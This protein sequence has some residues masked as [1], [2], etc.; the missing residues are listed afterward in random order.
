MHRGVSQPPAL[1]PPVRAN[2]RPPSRDAS[3]LAVDREGATATGSVFTGGHP[4]IPH[5]QVVAVVTAPT[6]DLSSATCRGLWASVT[7][8]P[9]ASQAPCEGETPPPTTLP[10]STRTQEAASSIPPAVFCLLGAR[11]PVW[12]KEIL[13]VL[14]KCSCRSV[15]SHIHVPSP[16]SLPPSPSVCLSVRPSVRGGRRGYLPLSA[17]PGFCPVP[18]QSSAA[19]ASPGD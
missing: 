10:N 13:K 5:G 2:H 16:S 1:P 12:L 6:R 11:C 17:L 15:R 7:A 14:I 8:P 3:A 4:Y 19:G 18:L 9:R